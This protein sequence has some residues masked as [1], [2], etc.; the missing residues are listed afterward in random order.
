[1]FSGDDNQDGVI[2]LSDLVLTYNDVLTF[3]SGYFTTDNNNDEISDLSDLIIA[4][5][6]GAAFASIIRP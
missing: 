6:N 2:D 1:M 4:Y 5:N 3:S